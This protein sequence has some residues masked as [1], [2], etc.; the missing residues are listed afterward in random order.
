MFQTKVVEKI[1]THNFFPDDRGTYE[2]KM[3]QKNAVV[4]N[5]PQMNII[6]HRRF[7]CWITK[8]TDTHWVSNIHC[9]STETIVTRTRPNIT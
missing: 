5:R 3:L 6:R 8:A 1:K 2:Y 4:R 7:T 9:F